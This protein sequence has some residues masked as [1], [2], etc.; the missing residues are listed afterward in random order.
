MQLVQ[1]FE[2][3]DAVRLGLDRVQGALVE[4]VYPET[5]A[6]AC[7][8][9]VDDVVLQVDS[10]PIKNENHLINMISGL[11][12]GQRVQV[13]VWRERRTVTLSAVVGDWT[14]AQSRF[15]QSK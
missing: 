3:G 6:A 13:Q 1:A 9:K 2:A 15:Q 14:A 11:A 7:G 12:P 4:A 8:M 10:V 5:P